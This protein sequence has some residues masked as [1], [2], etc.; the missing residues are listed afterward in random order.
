MSEDRP[1]HPDDN[2][3][4]EARRMRREQT[5]YV[6]AYKRLRRGCCKDCFRALRCYE[7]GPTCGEE[8]DHCHCNCQCVE[9]GPDGAKALGR[10]L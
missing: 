4:A 2:I 3:W 7:H 5:R 8:P 6:V 9:W 10:G 1:G